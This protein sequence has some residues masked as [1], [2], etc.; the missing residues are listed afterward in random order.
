MNR[1]GSDLLD[2]F[3]SASKRPSGDGGGGAAAR[4]GGS[5]LS[6]ARRHLVVVG[7]GAALLLVLAFVVGIGIGRGHKKP[8]G[9]GVPLAS[10]ATAHSWRLP[11]AALPRI[12]AQ[13][14]EVLPRVKAAFERDWP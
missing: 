13:A 12:G 9:G 3:R 14:Q 6:L 10:A 2:V 1:K 5:A 7:A 11:G 4:Y 8:V